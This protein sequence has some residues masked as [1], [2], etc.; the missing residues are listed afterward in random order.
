[1]KMIYNNF[2]NRPSWQTPFAYLEMLFA[3][4]S[5]IQESVNAFRV[6]LEKAGE[7]MSE[8]MHDLGQKIIEGSRDVNDVRMMVDFVAETYRRFLEGERRKAA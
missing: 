3:S 8:D 6:W 1:L 5:S 2:G 7:H 4:E